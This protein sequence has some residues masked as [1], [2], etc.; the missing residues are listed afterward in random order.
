MNPDEGMTLSEVI[1]EAQCGSEAKGYD[2]G[3]DAGLEAA[4]QL[5][6]KLNSELADPKSDVCGCFNCAAAAIRALK[7]KP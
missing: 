1:E 5:M 3:Y 7:E 4:A 2:E 6:D